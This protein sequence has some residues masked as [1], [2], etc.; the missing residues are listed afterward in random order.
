MARSFRGSLLL[1]L[2]VTV[3]LVALAPAVAATAAT[4]SGFHAGHLASSAASWGNAIEVPGNAALNAGGY[5]QVSSVSC[6][7]TGNCS[8]GG[9]YVDSSS[10]SQA[11]VVSQ[12]NST[13]GTAIEVPGTGSLNAG[14]NAQVNSVSCA[15]AG[16][17]GAGGSY[18]DASANTQAFVANQ[19]NGIWGNAREVPGT[20]ALNAGG[21]AQVNSV[22]CGS[23]GNCSAGGSYTDA[24][25]ATQ[26][27]VVSEVN[28][29]W[30]N[31]IEVPG[32]ASLNAA[33][34]AQVS[35]VSCGSA[36]NCSAGGYYTDGSGGVQAFV[37][38]QVN[39][40]WG[41]AI[42]TPGTAALN[43]GGNAV[44]GSVSCASAG[45]CSAGGYYT[46]GSGGLQ[47]LVASQVNGTWG[48]AA[49]VPG[50]GSLNVGGS[51]QT[52]SVSC[53][54]PGNCS[55]GGYYFSSSSGQ[56]QA[57]ADSEVN[58]TWGTA[59]EVPGT[60]SLNSGG[61]AQA[62]SVSCAS[63]G[64][65]SIGGS[66]TD[67]SGSSQVWVSD[68][69]SGTW[70]TAEEIP[71]TSTLNQT[72]YADLYSAAC[73]P[74]GTCSVGGQYQDGSGKIQAFVATQTAADTV[75]VAN[76][77]NQSTYQNSALSLQIAG[78]SSAGN[79]LTWFATG[80]PSG[81]TIGPA[82]G[83]I[84]GKITA[85]P[86]TYSV[87]VSATDGTGASGSASFTWTVKADV[88][89]SIS[90]QASGTCLNDHGYSITPGNQVV[91]WKCL[92]GPA[93]MFSHPANGELIVLGQCLTDPGPGGSATMQVVEPCTG[94]SNQVW[95][96]NGTNEYV[97]QKNSLCL[98]DPSGSTL[99]GA[100]VEVAKCTNAK[101]QHW[102]G[103]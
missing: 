10:S 42:E 41:S 59:I 46:D 69:A 21:F 93:E 54:S 24:S 16:N 39:G 87:T 68:E 67:S 43:A 80:L 96:H 31:A 33:G 35:S 51:A 78:T 5:S 44:L 89:S 86:A 57:F 18:T 38:S 60:G 63:A 26:A 4:F 47:A 3:S 1:G 72:G 58:G 7:S 103:T 19:V 12:V 100:P 8:A 102:F 99:N 49:E 61:F 65:C 88:G 29:T 36:G 40:T 73:A 74:A 37:A 13:W 28:G 45:N 9:G 56:S 48:A 15:T 71:G 55:A 22:S 92:N 32:V 66:Y 97:L 64:N 84:S 82:N 6:P 27:F 75:T 25:D 20:A 50:T 91:M 62:N 70:G 76:P 34:E 11:F 53:A 98:T 79:P 101:N 52:S 30:G 95:S 2:T 90:N 23:A 14:G 85:A 77:G 83:L 94:A 17:C 81:L